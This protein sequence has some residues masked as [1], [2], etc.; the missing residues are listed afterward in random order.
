MMLIL[1]CM[2]PLLLSAGVVAGL[3]LDALRRLPTQH[4]GRT[5]PLDTLA[6]DLVETVTGTPMFDGHDPVLL[7]L[8]W[9]FDADA[10]R[11]KPLIPISNAELRAVLKLPADRARFSYADLARHEPLTR[12]IEALHR[13]ADGKKLNP[14]E[15]KVKE[16]AE[17]LVTL[18]TVL[19]GLALPLIPDPLH[20]LHPWRPIGVPG[21]ETDDPEAVREAWTALGDALRNRNTATFSAAAKQLATALNALPAAYRPSAAVIAAELHYNELRPHRLAWQML[22]LG[23]ACAALATLLDGRWAG[24]YASVKRTAGLL[25]VVAFA[26]GAGM[27]SYGLWLRW[28]LAGRLP[29]TNMYESMLFLGWGAAVFAVLAGGVTT[30]LRRGWVVP[31]TGGFM[32]ALALCLADVLPLD[33][34]L[35][36]TAPVLLDT[37]WM[38]IHV[39]IMMTSYAVLALAV[40]IAHA[41]LVIVGL[42]PGR[43][44]LVQAVDRVH[45]AYVLVGSILLIAGIATG[46]MWGAVSWGRYWGWDPKEVWALIAFLGYTVILHTRLETEPAPAW[47]KAVAAGLALGVFGVVAS[48]FGAPTQGRTLAFGGAALAGAFFVLARGPLATALKS[49]LAFWLILM[50]YVGVNFVLGIG[51]HSYGFG[52]G[53]VVR[54]MLLFGGADLIFVALCSLLHL[55]RS[56]P[57]QPATALTP[58][59][60]G[61]PAEA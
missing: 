36:P 55:W 11:Q 28:Q 4:D 39:P 10:W 51:L 33:R 60:V 61:V 12:P 25:A 32:A 43:S 40:A 58:A 50:T 20:V 2:S 29:E 16:I 48:K 7:V 49:V 42:A 17:R 38:S 34:Y 52:A 19:S 30:A 6:R 57:P 3:D 37:V 59:L 9:T 24:S 41:Q 18:D 45:Y 21:R 1:R 14:L 15:T 23:L 54:Y 56:R 53:A 26:A 47:A 44:D 5:P 31:L 22:A 27:Q 46:S 35:R 13:R 8:A